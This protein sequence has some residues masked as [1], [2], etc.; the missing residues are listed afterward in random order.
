M[1]QTLLKAKI[2]RHKRLGELLINAGLLSKAQLDRALVM[3]KET[4]QRLGQVLVTQEFV[5]DKQIAECLS[6]QLNFPLVDLA[7]YP[8]N[9]MTLSLVPRDIASRY[10]VF[11]I[12]TEGQRLTLAMADPLNIVAEDA[13]RKHSGMEIKPVIAPESQ[14]L[15]YILRFYSENNEAYDLLEQITPEFEGEEISLEEAQ[16]NPGELLRASGFESVVSVVKAI[17]ANAVKRSASDIHLE[18]YEQTIRLRYRIDGR[19]RQVA[20]LPRQVYPAIVSRF[21]I[22]ANLDIAESR[23]PQD[24]SFKAMVGHRSFSFRLSTL[25]T[26]YGEKLVLRI[27]DNF[28]QKVNLDALGLMGRD[29][30]RLENL[31]FQPQGLV[32]VTGPTGSGKTT[33]L[34]AALNRLRADEINIVTVEDPIEYQ[35]AGI[36]QVQ[37]DEKAGVS[38]SNLLRTILRQDPNV[39][40]IGEIRDRE[41]LEIAIRASLTGHLVLA[42]LH[43]NN[44]RS[45][46]TRLIDMGIEPYLLASSLSGVI[47]QRLVRRLC[48]ECSQPM[49]RPIGCSMCGFSGY[50]GR[51]GIYELMTAEE[52]VRR[53]IQTADEEKIEE[54]AYRHGYRRMEEDAAEKIALG[55]TTPKQVAL[56]ITSEMEGSSGVNAENFGNDVRTSP[57]LGPVNQAPETPN[58]AF[59]EKERPNPPGDL[60]ARPSASQPLFTEEPVS[61]LARS[62]LPF[63]EELTSPA[64]SAKSGS[65]PPPPVEKTVVEKTVAAKTAPEERLPLPAGDRA[66]AEPMPVPPSASAAKYVYENHLPPHFSPFFGREAELEQIRTLLL[67]EKVRFVTLTGPAGCGKTRLAIEAGERLID[68]FKGRVWHIPLADLRDPQMIPAAL[69]EAVNVPVSIASRPADQLAEVFAHEPTLLLLDT[70]EHLIEGGVRILLHLLSR[71]P[72][73][74]CLITSRHV[75]NVSGEREIPVPP[76]PA[77]KKT[78][79]PQ[80]LM[81]FDSVQLFVDRAAAVNPSFELNA[82]NADAV[83]MICNRLEGIPLAIELAAARTRVFAPAQLLDHLKNRYEV[84]VSNKRDIP[85]RHRTLR[86]AID[87][88][89]R[90][91]SP[92]LQ[93]FFARLSVFRG[94]WSTYAAQWICEEPQALEYLETLREYSLIVMESTKGAPLFVIREGG[95]KTW[96]GSVDRNAGLEE[97]V[98]WGFLETIREYA[99]ERL[100]EAGEGNA[101]NQ[102][103]LQYLTHIAFYAQHE[104]GTLRSDRLLRWY[105]SSQDTLRGAL[106]WGLEHQPNLALRLAGLMG[107]FWYYRGSISEGREW[108]ARALEKAKGA[109]ER[110]RIRA[111]WNAGALALYQGAYDAGGKYLKSA[112]ALGRKAF[113]AAKSIE[114]R[115]YIGG[116]IGEALCHLGLISLLK[117]DHPAAQSYFGMS[118]RVLQEIDNKGC[119]AKVIGFLG[120]LAEAKG[121]FI[122]A[123]VYYQE[124]EALMIEAESFTEYA[125]ALSCRR[126]A[127]AEILLG[128]LEAGDRLFEESLTL[129]SQ[130]E[131]RS[132][133]GSALMGQGDLAYVRGDADAAAV[134]LRE[135]LT[136]FRSYGNQR[137]IARALRRLA[138][139]EAKKGDVAKAARLFGAA[140]ALRNSLGIR[141]LPH[142]RNDYLRTV[143]SVRNAL[144]DEI[145]SRAWGEGKRLTWTKAVAYGLDEIDSL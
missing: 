60:F 69:L 120:E 8:P 144:G 98:Q 23:R 65:V 26:N 44:A 114:D 62:S 143:E 56:V 103:L 38:F 22:L 127:R 17:L 90:L 12:Q 81:R 91:L 97:G 53:A 71:C 20:V 40:M 135:C 88:S 1:D 113:P 142:Q 25:R 66:S 129:S 145:F 108:L 111:L 15:E 7:N 124:S 13:V 67:E 125:K 76:L 73:L 116:F 29:Q 83:A 78:G 34:Y 134:K 122:E 132:G 101:L 128:D 80:E 4:H 37:V 50:M 51:V 110:W 49:K 87:W 79:S 77:P 31:I 63:M 121:D 36:N 74:T 105:D 68:S 21:K 35:L 6:S 47:A 64:P 33:T 27:L 55:W 93:A 133:M 45:T 52:E 89:Y 82:E 61:D 41:T 30:E 140:E 104:L 95:A 43:T 28:M 57:E 94:G 141:L 16:A 119:M 136:I 14:V 92:E 99:A 102:R 138:A 126:L 32:L 123:K 109:P 11:P 3:Q 86:S 131:D 46:P 59:G 54:A 75:L 39:I 70:F 106:A 117:S 5:T 9:P 19:L 118:L 84:L 10:M 42:T 137:D 2:N 115:L 58:G 96:P 130:I 100:E 24:G 107:S 85:E 48:P 72:L 112:V 18:P 139:S